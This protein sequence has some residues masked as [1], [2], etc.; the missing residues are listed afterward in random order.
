M[1]HILVILLSRIIRG[2]MLIVSQGSHLNY[3]PG[4][5]IREEREKDSKRKIGKE[6]E[7]EVT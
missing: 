1:S 7:E 3:Y 4:A 5:K 2:Y 6:E